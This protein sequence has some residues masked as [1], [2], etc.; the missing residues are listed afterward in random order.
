MHRVAITPRHFSKS[1]SSSSIRVETV[2]SVPTLSS[3]CSRYRAPLVVVAS[4]ARRTAL[5]EAT[6]RVARATLTTT[7]TLVEIWFTS[8]YDDALMQVFVA[9]GVLFRC[10]GGG[11]CLCFCACVFL[12][13]VGCV[14]VEWAHYHTAY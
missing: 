3:L 2:F 4:H 12:C 9:H 11:L 1:I 10:V 5:V 14:W 6:N 7:C 13:Y 8:R